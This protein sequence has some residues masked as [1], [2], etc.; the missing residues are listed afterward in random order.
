MSEEPTNEAP[1]RQVKELTRQKEVSCSN[2]HAVIDHS[3]DAS[4]RICK[5]HT[6]LLNGS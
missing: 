2:Y 4:I 1:A 6:R 3:M 5:K